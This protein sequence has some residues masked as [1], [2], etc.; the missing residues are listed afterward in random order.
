MKKSMEEIITERVK[1]EVVK[2]FHKN[3]FTIRVNENN[4]DWYLYNNGVKQ[5]N[6]RFEY[7]CKAKVNAIAIYAEE[8]CETRFGVVSSYYFIKHIDL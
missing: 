8:V 2:G 6:V 7:N 5:I 4:I 1:N 3:S